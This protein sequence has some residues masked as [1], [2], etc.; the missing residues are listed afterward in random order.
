MKDELL[1]RRSV[2]ALT[3][4]SGPTIWRRCKEGSFPLPIKIST[5]RVAWR[6]SDVDGWINGLSRTDGSLVASSDTAPKAA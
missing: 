4:L 1:P 5:K 6:R 2:I 3:S